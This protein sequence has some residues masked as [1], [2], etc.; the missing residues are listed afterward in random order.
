MRTF[1]STLLL[2][3]VFASFAPTASFAVWPPATSFEPKENKTERPSSERLEQVVQKL[4]EHERQLAQVLSNL[5]KHE[6]KL[7]EL[8][9]EK[10]S[11]TRIKENQDGHRLP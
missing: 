8:T 1:I 2:W 4:E 7:D 3:A 6:K 9:E 5:E 10:K 11:E